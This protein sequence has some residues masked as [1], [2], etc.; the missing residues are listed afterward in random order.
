MQL[1][2]IARRRPRHRGAVAPATASAHDPHRPSSSRPTTPPA[3]RV[4]AYDRDRRRHADAGRHVRHRRP[5]RRPR[6]VGRRPPRLA[7]L[8]RPTTARTACCTRSTPAATRVTVFG[9]DGDRLIRRAGPRLRRR[10]PG[11][12]RHPRQ[13]RLRAQRPRRRLHPGLPAAR[14]PPRPD[15]GMAPRARPRPDADAG[16][17][18]HPRPGRVHPGRRAAGRHDQGQ[19]QRHRRVRASPLG[20]SSA[21]AGRQP[22][23]GRRPVRVRVRRPRPTSSSPRPARTRSPRSGSTATA[24]SRRSTQAATGQA[25]TCWVVADGSLLYLPTPAA[26]PCPDT[27]RQA[28]DLTAL[29]QHRHRRRHRRRGRHARTAVSSMCRPAPPASSTRSASA[30]TARSPRSARSPS[31]ARSAAKASP[32]P[33]APARGASAPPA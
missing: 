19:R 30:R 28:A 9:V 1:P 14:R 33:D 21:A 24:R 22:R 7:G 25:A 12:R 2:R 26:P 6:R 10:L 23:A 3:T 32:P 17:H 31:P 29:G 27:R 16:V 5:R 8:A 11:Q 20:G 18:P 13:P 15:P 4:V